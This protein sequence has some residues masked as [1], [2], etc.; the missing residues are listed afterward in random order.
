MAYTIRIDS[1][2]TSDNRY[3]ELSSRAIRRAQETEDLDSF[4][5][6]VE[7]SMRLFE[8]DY[9]T[10]KYCI[11]PRIE[12]TQQ[13]DLLEEESPSKRIEGQLSIFL[14]IDISSILPEVDW[15]E[16]VT[17]EH[18]DRWGIPFDALLEASIRNIEKKE[19]PV[20]KILEAEDAFGTPVYQVYTGENI[21]SFPAYDTGIVLSGKFLEQTLKKLK[22]PY[23]IFFMSAVSLFIAPVRG[24]SSR[25]RERIIRSAYEPPDH[26]SDTVYL[27]DG[28]MSLYEGK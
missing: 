5:H 17:Y 12:N 20:R 6:I 13:A 26:L 8:S 23:L 24:G 14:S 16:D 27:Y 28:T 11:Y 7:E 22:E 21:K 19:F 10:L 18:L 3:E 9:E 4:D 15:T 25:I 1:T 2:K